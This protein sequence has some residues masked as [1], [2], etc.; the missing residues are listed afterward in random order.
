[1]TNLEK[2][3]YNALKSMVSAAQKQDWTNHYPGIMVTA[4]TAMEA[5]ENPEQDA[6]T[7]AIKSYLKHNLEIKSYL[8]GD[9]HKG[10][11]LV[12]VL[13]LEGEE[14]SVSESYL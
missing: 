8:G 3:L 10:I 9:L 6:N 14:I 1:M 11:N 5:Y 12:T 7:L 13:E 4:Y 2:Q